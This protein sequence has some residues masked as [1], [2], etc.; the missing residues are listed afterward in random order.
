[1]PFSFFCLSVNL[2][3]FVIFGLMKEVGNSGNTVVLVLLLF[4]YIVSAQS[5]IIP[6]YLDICKQ[7]NLQAK[8]KQ[9]CLIDKNYVNRHNQTLKS[10][11]I[12]NMSQTLNVWTRIGNNL[13]CTVED[14]RRLAI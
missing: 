4:L 14:R 10:T 5:R 2:I 1:M 3:N 12:L 7:L 9:K 6:S 11:L 8:S 13:N